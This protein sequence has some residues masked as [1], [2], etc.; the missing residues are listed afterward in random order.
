MNNRS[1]KAGLLLGAAFGGAVTASPAL[2]QATDDSA[3]GGDIIVTAR[4]TEERL[5]DVPISITVFSQ[6]A[7]SNRNVVTAT[8]LATYTPSLSVNQRFGPEKASFSIRGFVQENSTAPSVGV[9]FADVVFGRAQGGTTSGGNAV[10]GSFMDL[11]NVQVLK[12]PQGTLFGRNTTG[13]AVLLVPQKPTDR[14]EGYVEASAGDFDMM[15]GQ[16]VLNIPLADTFKVR[17]AVDRNKREGYMRNHSGI[18]P[19]DYN[20]V[21]YFAAR[22]SIVQDLTPDLENYIVATY[23]HSFSHGYAGRIIACNRATPAAQV[24]AANPQ[25]TTNGVTLLQALSACDQIARQ[26]ARGDGPLDVDINN[27]KGLINLHHWQ[28]IN[29]TTWK[30][31][32][33]LTIKNIASFQEFRERA[34]YSLN[35][36][37]FTV[38]AFETAG[39]VTGYNVSRISP[40]LPAIILPAGSAYQQTLLNPR[41]SENNSAES[42]FTEELQ[43]QGGSSDGS[44]NYVLGGYVEIARPIGWSAGR[45]VTNALCADGANLVCSNPLLFGGLSQSAIRSSFTTK[46]LFAQGTYKFTEQLSVTGGI[47]YTWD[48]IKVRANNTRLTLGIPAFGTGNVLRCNNPITFPAVGGG[49]ITVTSPEQCPEAF[50][51][52]S[53]KPTWLIDIDYKP[54]PDVLLYAKWARGYRSGGANPTNVGLE[55]WQP[56][57]VDTYEAG[58]KATFRGATPGYIN[59][60]AFYNDFTNQQ[61]AAN[62]VASPAAQGAGFSGSQPIVNA[63]KSRIQGL[64]VDGSVTFF[65]SLKF[66][67]GYA[68][69]DSKLK[70][71]TQVPFPA[72]VYSNLIYSAAI[73]GPL[74][75][76]PKHRLTLTG[77]YTLP[78]DESIGRIS[79][80]ATYIYTSTQYFSRADTNFAPCV[81]GGTNATFCRNGFGFSNV[82]FYGNDLGKLPSTSLVNLNVNWDG[83]LGSPVDASFFMT[84]VTN[85]IYPVALGSALSSNG[86]E[87]FQYAPPRMW[88]VRLR[89]SFGN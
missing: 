70:S 65:D 24:T 48:T 42:T 69:I 67:L 9:Y 82:P 62:G 88:G 16:A 8:D 74:A 31:S 73:G 29:T 26:N 32:D 40:R 15:R 46:A 52:K 86:Y 81:A 57:Q 75:L 4:R 47:R 56:E 7:I 38:P 2:A 50:P 10:V 87:T 28:V 85:K 23:S 43:L 20:D 59:V 72:A 78:L 60:A 6:E 61:L 12:G 30:A 49:A 76:T 68:Y 55:T 45:T 36:D 83:V 11:Q 19:K 22:M 53:S 71:I 39:G 58:V 80:G 77:T 89:Y 21:N 44:L 51:T 84:N 18:G 25:F 17:F 1:L 63:G 5:Q 35:S 33:T 66:D 79:V 3:S 64:E 14:L 13:G 37:N 34:F 54:T 27:P 41:G